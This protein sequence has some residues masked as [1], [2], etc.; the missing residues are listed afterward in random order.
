M[1]KVEILLLPDLGAMEMF[2]KVNSKKTP[3]KSKRKTHSKITDKL[4]AKIKLRFALR[5]VTGVFLYFCME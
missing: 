3:F 1:E 4:S 2:S 5:L